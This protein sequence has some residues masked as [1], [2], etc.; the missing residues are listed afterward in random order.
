MADSLRKLLSPLL[1]VSGSYR[2]RWH[3]TDRS[4]IVLAYHRIARRG[5]RGEP[6]GYGVECG[7]PV[8]LFEA[9][10]RFLMRH[11]DPSSAAAVAT[12]IPPSG[13]PHFAI[14]FDDGY[15]DNLA[16]AA[17]I[18]ERHGLSAT[19]FVNSDLV[20]S[21]RRF[22]WEQLGALLRETPARSLDVEAAAAELLPRFP[23]PAV[24]SLGGDAARGRAHWL[25]S[26][27]L[28]RTPH[29]EIDA[30]LEALA[31]AL[32]TP[33]KRESRDVP[34]LDWS[35]LR[36]WRRRGF[37]VGAHGASHANLG[38]ADTR[39]SE[40]EVRESVDRISAEVDAP[41][42]LFA[43]PYGGPEHRNPA[44]VDAIER[45]GCEAAFTTELGIVVPESGRYALP[46]VG[47]GGAA[48]F[49]CAY[50][51]DRAFRN[52]RVSRQA[53]RTMSG[54]GTGAG[55]SARAAR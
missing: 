22:W 39:E 53:T 19:V 7:L 4:G 55:A 29:P 28:M 42:T 1:H 45:A 54:G 40:R 51:T 5:G 18:L 8:D 36:E 16:L 11:F 30:T 9:Q 21:D 10:L 38:L 23:L 35:Q 2:R 49:V 47:L 25:L 32:E 13:R 6:P 33:L 14:T 31:F 44:A 24:L 20:G 43:Y 15:A 52:T 46:R 12:G 48:G 17:P 26:M 41:V 34:L 3:A 27:A 37:D 50:Q